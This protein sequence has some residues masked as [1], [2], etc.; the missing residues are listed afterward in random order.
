MTSRAF[1]LVLALTVGMASNAGAF[2]LNQHAA[3]FA[4]AS[5]TPITDLRW[6]PDGVCVVGASQYNYVI[7][8][9]DHT[10]AVGGEES[11]YVD[12]KNEGTQSIALS[13]ISYDYHGMMRYS[14]VLNYTEAGAWSHNWKSTV[15]AIW[16]YM[17]VLAR[18]PGGCKTKILGLMYLD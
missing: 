17:S 8:S 9:V 16:D 7:A 10:P 5:G 2:Q 13:L 18:I 3:N 15:P 14:S 1:P 12:G 11:V 4:A 6:Y